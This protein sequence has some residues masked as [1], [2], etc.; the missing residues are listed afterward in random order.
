MKN[1]E[2]K[3]RENAE[4]IFE[5]KLPEAHRERF[6]DKLAKAGKTKRR[7][8]ILRLAYSTS[9][10]AAILVGLLIFKPSD[11]ENTAF[12]AN[13]EIRIAD[14][15]QY[16]AMQLENEIEATKAALK[17]VDAENRQRIIAD[18]EKMQTSD[19]DILSSRL[20]DEKKAALLCSNYSRKVEVLQNL[21]RNLN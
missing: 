14:V 13:K 20:D 2:E 19:N 15:Q 3:I 7:A 18:M 1:I 8:L 10:A 4:K 11:N 16:Y 21:Q 12:E 9:V 6:A 17:N 5:A